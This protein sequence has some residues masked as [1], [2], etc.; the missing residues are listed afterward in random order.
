MSFVWLGDIVDGQNSCRAA[1][2]QSP[3]LVES[4]RQ[5]VGGV[6]RG[7]ISAF[8]EQSHV[9]SLNHRKDWNFHDHMTTWRSHRRY[10]TDTDLCPFLLWC[11]CLTCD[12]DVDGVAVEP[13]SGLTPIHPRVWRDEVIQEAAGFVGAVAWAET[14]FVGMFGRVPHH[15]PIQEVS[16]RLT[17]QS[18]WLV[19]EEL[20]LVGNDR[21]QGCKKK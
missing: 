13:W 8:A 10:F 9:G 21:E 15:F 16:Q 3:V 12:R 6:E 20:G 18:H 11:I 5:A 14:L 17:L 7:G 4:P 1:L 19:L 2:H